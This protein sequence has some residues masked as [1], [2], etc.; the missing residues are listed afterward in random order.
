MG[1]HRLP[2]MFH[3]ETQSGGSPTIAYRG[4]TIRVSSVMGVLKKHSLENHIVML[5][6]IRYDM[7]LFTKIP[8]QKLWN[9]VYMSK[10]L[11]M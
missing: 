6:D 1:M 4:E 7:R 11:A 8:T 5:S 9:Q 10:V 3:R 2:Q